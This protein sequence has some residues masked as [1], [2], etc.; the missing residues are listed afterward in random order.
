M[1]WVGYVEHIGESGGVCCVLVGKSQVRRPLGN[2]IHRWDN[3]IKKD[4][5]EVGWRAMDWIG[6]GEGLLYMR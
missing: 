2:P 5:Q 4:R 6:T 3:D 1:R